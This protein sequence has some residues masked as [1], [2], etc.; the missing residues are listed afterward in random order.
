MLKV[1]WCFSDEKMGRKVIMGVKFYIWLL[2]QGLLPNQK[3]PVTILSCIFWKQ[4]NFPQNFPS[5][6]IPTKTHSINP[7]TENSHLHA[8]KD[9]SKLA[10]DKF[11]R[12]RKNIPIHNNK[13]F[14]P[15]KQSKKL[16]TSHIPMIKI[17]I[18]SLFSTFIKIH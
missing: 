10:S 9:S 2:L 15:E 4:K 1:H 12:H 16:K 3:T 13:L 7:P 17:T 11:M 18:F 14:P 8:K 5:N 6:L